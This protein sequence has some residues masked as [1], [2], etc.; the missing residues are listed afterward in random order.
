MLRDYEYGLRLLNCDQFTVD[1]DI[2]ANP[3]ERLEELI[4]KAYE[5]K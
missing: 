4:K 1:E 2:V 5:N 3:K